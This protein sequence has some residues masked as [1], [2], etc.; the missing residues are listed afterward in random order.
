MMQ[1]DNTFEDVKQK[2]QEGV[3]TWG[4]AYQP[5]VEH[6]CLK[7]PSGTWWTS[8]GQADTGDTKP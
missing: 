1:W 4:G 5:Q 6:W 7:K 2:L 3:D 8:N